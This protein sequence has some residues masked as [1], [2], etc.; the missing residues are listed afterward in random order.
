MC[1]FCKQATWSSCKIINNGSYLGP[2]W[3]L[4]KRKSRN[5]K[6]ETLPHLTWL[7]M[8]HFLWIVG[9]C[10]S[11]VVLDIWINT[12]SSSTVMAD[13]VAWRGVAG[14]DIFCWRRHVMM[15]APTISAIFLGFPSI[16]RC[17][18]KACA[19]LVPCLLGLQLG[20]FQLATQ[21]SL[22]ALS[23][24]IGMTHGLR[25]PNDGKNQRNLK[26]L[27]DVTDKTCFGRT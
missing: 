5:E 24:W 18:C 25:T 7:G 19:A 8:L 1:I 3:G 14:R 20:K 23:R 17:R 27:A 12:T 9:N 22:P 16:A 21:Q 2:A 13:G 4:M 6:N 15:Q 11:I 26:I 10:R